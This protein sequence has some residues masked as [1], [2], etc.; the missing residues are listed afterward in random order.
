MS[1][2]INIEHELFDATKIVFGNLSP[3]HGA[4]APCSGAPPFHPVA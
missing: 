3:Q 4:S 1:F 2:F